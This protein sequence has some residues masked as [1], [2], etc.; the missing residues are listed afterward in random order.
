LR[1]ELVRPVHEALVEI[2]TEIDRVPDAHKRPADVALFWPYA[3]A[4]LDDATSGAA[5]EAACDALIA[6]LDAQPTRRFALHDGLAGAC[7]I[8]SHITGGSVSGLFA[9]DDLFVERLQR[10]PHDFDVIGG[11]AGDAIYLLERLA[12][13][14]PRAASGLACVVEHLR[15][16]AVIDRDGTS[17][18]TPVSRLTAGI[19]KD[20][21]N[22]HYDCGVAHGIPGVVGALARIATSEGI[23]DATRSIARSLATGGLSWMRARMLPPHPYGRFP[24]WLAAGHRPPEPAPGAWCYGEPGVAVVLWAAA[25]RLGESVEPWR[26]LARDSARRSVEDSSVHTPGLC[27]GAA[28]L[29]HLFGRCYRTTQEPVFAEAMNRWIERALAMRVPGSGPGGFM[30]LG[31]GTTAQPSQLFLL[32]VTGI[33][34]ALSAALGTAEPG[35][36]R[37]LVCDLPDTPIAA[38]AE[39]RAPGR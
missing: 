9:F 3:A 2:A 37:L 4:I 28:G 20:W 1:N 13:G 17:W 14:S 24:R 15:S 32:G 5:S 33:G 31:N 18:F 16:L 38:P 6:H 12:V 10:G 30:M 21:P 26:E 11:V 35:W 34:L 22:G 29:A 27:H 7:W 19:A 25:Q 23:D 36:D 39:F 8:L